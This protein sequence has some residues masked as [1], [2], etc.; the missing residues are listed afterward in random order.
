MSAAH[1]ERLGAVRVEEVVKSFGHVEALRGASLEA[2]AGEVLV[3]FGDNG[4]GKSTLMNVIAGVHRPDSGAV[5]IGGEITTGTGIA[6]AQELG[7]QTVFQ[8]LALAPD[9]S[10]AENMFLGHEVRRRGRFLPL[11]VLDR[12]SMVD[13]ATRALEQLS[14]RLPSASAPVSLL[15][16]GQRQ[17]VA[18]A[19]A[20]MWARLA[21]LMDEP[22]AALGA[23]QSDIVCETIRATAS[24]GLAV[25]VVS[26]DILRM[27]EAAD[28]VAIMRRGRV[29]H[30]GPTTELSVRDVVAIMVGEESETAAR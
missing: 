14:I 28:R 16:G 29:V 11:P 2:H 24:R 15:S 19:R 7:V 27:L 4:A 17:A 10:V 9:L 6:H 23:R 18:V 22:T 3:V 1:V 30:D 25:I 20:V 8:D 5:V 21:V 13:A 26:H 12:R